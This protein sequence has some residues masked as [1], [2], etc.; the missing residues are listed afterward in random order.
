MKIAKN[1]ISVVIP[2]YNS[3][4]TIILVLDS[5]NKQTAR[6]FIREII[7]VNDGSTDSSLELVSNYKMTS[8]IPISIINKTNGGVSSARNIGM[9]NAHGDWIAFCDSD[10]IWLSDKIATQVKIV[11][12]LA[13][14]TNIDFIG[15]N[16]RKNELRILCKTIR[17]IHK[18][19]I[20][21]L[22]IKMFPQTSTVIMKK[23]IYDSIGG[24][25]ESQKY[26]EDGNY[27][28]KIASK[29]DCFYIPKQLVIYDGGKREFGASGLSGNLRG[30][31][32][33]NLKNL[34][35]LRINKS[36]SGSF[37]CLMYLYFWLKYCRRF[38]IIN[39]TDWLRNE[40]A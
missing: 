4:R 16:H 7:V 35:D 27:F 32:E 21:E 39:I 12:G 24:F 1:D 33:G 15:G 25:D 11:N 28:L 22:C 18:A 17:K 38:L 26:A 9:L 6:E 34:K 23:S 31:H 36:I 10:D 29:Y 30:M 8:A 14:K 20:V 13:Q 40:N 2:M 3:E 19:N 5:I 37:Y